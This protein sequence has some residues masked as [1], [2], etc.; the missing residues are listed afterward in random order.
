MICNIYFKK[1]KNTPK[2]AIRTGVIHAPHARCDQV[3]NNDP[4]SNI[5][6]QSTHPVWGATTTETVIIQC[7]PFQSTHPVWDA[8][9]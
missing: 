7:I 5:G 8:T 3:E 2:G 6:F 1:I 9:V 4:T